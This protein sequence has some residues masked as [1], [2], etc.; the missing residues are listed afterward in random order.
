MGGVGDESAAPLPMGSRC[1]DGLCPAG[2]SPGGGFTWT[3]TL[4]TLRGNV[5]PLSPASFP[6]AVAQAPREHMRGH[7]EEHLRGVGARLEVSDGHSR[8]HLDRH[9]AFHGGQPY[10]LAYGGAGGGFGGFGG[11]GPDGA[12]PTG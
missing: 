2:P 10:S 3:I 5:S 11:E 9:A 7:F 12:F 1:T 6:A 8:S 4:T